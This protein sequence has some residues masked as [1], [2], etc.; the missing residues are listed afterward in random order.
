QRV[1]LAEP[2]DAQI[3]THRQGLNEEPCNKGRL[4]AGAVG[5]QSER[6]AAA[7]TGETRQAE[8]TDGEQCRHPA[9]CDIRHHVEERA[10]MRSAAREVGERDNYELRSEERLRAGQRVVQNVG[11]DWSRR[12]GT[13]CCCSRW[14]DQ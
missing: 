7:E 6:E 8:H 1:E 13:M 4:G 10:R 9:E 11:W 5:N 3:G 14:A 2:A 12:I